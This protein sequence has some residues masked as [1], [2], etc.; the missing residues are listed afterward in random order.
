MTRPSHFPDGFPACTARNATLSDGTRLRVVESGA[1]DGA[2]VLLVHGF[3]ASAYQWR[4]LMPA[5]ASAGHRVI[6][7]DLPG[8]GFS[9]LSLPAGEYTRAAYAR[10]MWLLLDALGVMRAPVIGHSMGGA[11]AAEMAWQQ[12]ARVESL[13]LL[14]PAGFG[15]VPGRARV[16]RFVPDRVAPWARPFAS[17]Q[18]A[19]LILGDV[20]GPEGAWSRRD[21]EELLAPYGQPEIFRALLRTVKEFDFR[22]HASARLAQL[23]PGTLVLFG[24]HDQVVRPVDVAAR[25]RSIPEGRLVMLP[26]I[27]HLPQ[28]E[29][30][31]QVSA[32]LGAFV[33]ER[34]IASAAGVH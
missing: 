24:T 25:V 1:A 13:A 20:Y 18:A 11:I 23:P 31:E 12:P 3:G 15:M 10:R 16:L 7:P 2:P 22:L 4:Y 5:L 19:H 14:S 32:L 21:E 34:R 29:A 27:G 26:R 30:A 33:R 17:R 6:A 9:Q 8:H 28:V